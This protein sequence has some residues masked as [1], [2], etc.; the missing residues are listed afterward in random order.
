MFKFS[1]SALQLSYAHVS[2]VSRSMASKETRGQ[3]I[4]LKTAGIS[5]RDITE[6]LHVCRNTVFNVWKRYTETTTTSSKPIPG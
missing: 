2:I 3:I 6:Q 1:Q 5:N 4:P